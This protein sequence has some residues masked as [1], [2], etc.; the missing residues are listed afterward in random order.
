MSQNHQFIQIES[1]LNRNTLYIKSF[2]IN[3]KCTDFL[4]IYLTYCKV[5]KNIF[6]TKH[7]RHA[8]LLNCTNT[9]NTNFAVIN[10]IVR[11]CKQKA[12]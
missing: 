11:N 6:P 4:K 3:I 5:N 8:S 9:C 1:N 7:K 12:Y 10:I 2:T